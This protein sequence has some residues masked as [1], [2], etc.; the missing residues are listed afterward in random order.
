MSSS[1][2]RLRSMTFAAALLAYAMPFVTVSCPGGS[3]TL[4]GIQVA[5]GTTVEQQQLLGPPKTEH[6][7]GEPL[8]LAAL[9]CAVAGLASAVLRRPVAAA[10][11]LVIGLL[12]A[13]LLLLLR[14]KIDGAVQNQGMG[15][16]QVTYGV[17]YWTAV[18]GF[19]GSSL[20]S[21]A[22]RYVRPTLVTQTT[23][24]GAAP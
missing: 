12:G 18:L 4:T 15:M 19:A 5:V 20:A 14:S 9:L 1:V 10:A 22:S 16:F 13:V 21:L 8:A 2:H 7:D 3:Q 11:S 6:L 24:P 23:V 17:G